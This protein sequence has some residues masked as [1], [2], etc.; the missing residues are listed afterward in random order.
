MDQKI[1]SLGFID[2]K[3]QIIKPL[4]GLCQDLLDLLLTNK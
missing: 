2:K 1:A 3:E 4:R